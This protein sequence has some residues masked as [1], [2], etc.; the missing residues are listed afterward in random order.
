MTLASLPKD[1]PKPQAIFFD[2]DGTLADT[3]SFLNDAHSHVRGI[4]GM[5]PFA[6][7]EYKKYFGKPRDVLYTTIYGAENFEAA[8]AHFEDYVL[9]N[10]V[11]G[12]KPLSGASE[13]LKTL[14]DLG[15]PMGAVSNKKSDYLR[16][17]AENFGW[18][19]YFETYV[20]AGDA[21]NDKP[22]ADPL[23]M[24]MERMGVQRGDV[25][26]HIWF[27]GDTESDLK[28]A[29]N[30]VCTCVYIKGD[31]IDLSKSPEYS[32]FLIYET[33][34]DFA[35]DIQKTLLQSF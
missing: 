14:H 1:T 7:G 3:Y 10:H 20:G 5:P 28:C 11:K 8:K 18:A 32:P 34:Y 27:V 24:A 29:E 16:L 12:V 22:S 23:Y 19:H 31:G 35:R 25:N 33:C 4:F 26:D 21:P 2:W 17:E 9:E 15:I 6:E 13:L 30:A